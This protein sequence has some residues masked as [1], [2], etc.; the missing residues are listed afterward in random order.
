MYW[1][2]RMK[3]YQVTLFATARKTIGVRA[4]DTDAAHEMAVDSIDTTD[5]D[6]GDWEVLTLEIDDMEEVHEEED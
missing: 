1:E 5:F 4:P 3:N 6:L 2:R